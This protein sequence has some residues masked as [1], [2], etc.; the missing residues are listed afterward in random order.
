MA[1]TDDVATQ[2]LGDHRREYLTFEGE[3]N[4][5]RGWVVRVA[6]GEYAVEEDSAGTPLVTLGEG[7]MRRRIRLNCNP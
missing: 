2:P 7:D 5:G 3:V 6:R 4:G 1:N